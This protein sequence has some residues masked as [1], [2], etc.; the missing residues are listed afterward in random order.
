M[1]EEARRRL[2]EGD[3]QAGRAFERVVVEDVVRERGLHRPARTA[4][5]H[6]VALRDA[7][8]EHVLIEAADVGLDEGARHRV[9]HELIA[10]VTRNRPSSKSI[11]RYP[12]S[13]FVPRIFTTRR[14]RW[15]VKSVTMCIRRWITPSARNSSS[16][17]PWSTC[18]AT[19]QSGRSVTRK[20][21]IP[22]SRSHSNSR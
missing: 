6:D 11:A 16:W 9:P 18:P 2:L 7:S 21:V 15:A 20:L 4:D 14:R 13:C 17:R 19:T 1:F 22:R 8:A 12:V 5:E 3:V 10:R